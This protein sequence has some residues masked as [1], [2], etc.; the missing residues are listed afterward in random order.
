MKMQNLWLIEQSMKHPDKTLK[1]NKNPTEPHK[2]IDTTKMNPFDVRSPRNGRSR[3][4]G[5][6]KKSK[7]T[8]KS[9][10]RYTRK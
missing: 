1:K 10:K 2:P 3:G 8:K 4:G 5:K 9:K 7:K 6:S